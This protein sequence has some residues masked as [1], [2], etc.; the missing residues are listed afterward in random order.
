MTE[1]TWEHDADFSNNTRENQPSAF[2]L[3]AR[4][5]VD[6][7]ESEKDVDLPMIFNARKLPDRTIGRPRQILI[8]GCAGVGKLTLCK[9]IVHEFLHRQLWGKIFDR[10][11][12]IPLRDLKGK[13]S[14]QDLLH[15]YLQYCPQHVDY[16]DLVRA[17]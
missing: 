11:L 2:T 1:H 16:E 12:W 10:V 6:T 5:K 4:L 8:R 9:K 3:F 17:L 15:E 7:P 14:I 13:A